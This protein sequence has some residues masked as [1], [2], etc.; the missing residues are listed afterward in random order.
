MHAIK[1]KIITYSFSSELV[2]I[3]SV[4]VSRSKGS[5]VVET[6]VELGRVEEEDCF[7]ERMLRNLDRKLDTALGLLVVGAFVVSFLEENRNLLRNR[8]LFL[9]GEEVVVGVEDASSEVLFLYR[10]RMRVWKI[11]RKVL[12]NDL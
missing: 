11:K 10:G 2:R 7:L 3:E 9:L 4:V 6:V 1:W 5:D 12:L 8:E